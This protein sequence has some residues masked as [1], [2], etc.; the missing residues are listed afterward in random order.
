M[1][2]RKATKS[3]DEWLSE[4]ELASAAKQPGLAVATEP[5]TTFP[6]PT[7]EIAQP[8]AASEPLAVVTADV[9]ITEDEAASWFW[10]LLE[11]SGYEHW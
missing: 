2:K 1:V 9:V 8:Q 4:G 5:C 11:Q 7:A 3:L 6:P 10:A